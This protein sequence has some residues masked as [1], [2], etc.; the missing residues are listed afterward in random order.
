MAKSGILHFLK[1]KGKTNDSAIPF[2]K[3]V[4]DSLEASKKLEGDELS[5]EVARVTDSVSSLKDSPTK[6]QI[7]DSV[8]DLFLDRDTAITNK[9]E[10]VK[11]LDA[12]YEKAEKETLASVNDSDEE[13]KKKA[14][15][16]LKKLLNVKWGKE[17]L[18]IIIEDPTGNSA[19]ISDKAVKSKL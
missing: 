6:T 11:I 8:S 2:S 17:S 10:A 13:A 18:K 4:F 16:L 3:I 15:N 5:A 7:V 19:I 9:A 1:R 12:L 14:K